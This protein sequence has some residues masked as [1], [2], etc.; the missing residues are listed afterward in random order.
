MLFKLRA[1]V[2]LADYFRDQVSKPLIQVK[3]K[4]IIIKVQTQSF[5]FKNS[6]KHLPLEEI[7]RKKIEKKTAVK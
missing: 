5:M 7:Q 6:K 3:L 2:F 1:T 4:L